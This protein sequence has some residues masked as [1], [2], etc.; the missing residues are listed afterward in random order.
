MKLKDAKV[1]LDNIS[2]ELI[3]LEKY[4][5]KIE[6][7]GNYDADLYS[8]IDQLQARKEELEKYIDENEEEV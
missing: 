2:R 8:K 1:E 6:D 5:E 7:E 4:L 3:S